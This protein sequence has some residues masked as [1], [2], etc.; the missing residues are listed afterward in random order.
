MT[1]MVIVEGCAPYSTSPYFLLFPRLRTPRRD[2]IRRMLGPWVTRVATSHL[3]TY[4]GVWPGP[5]AHRRSSVTATGRCAGDNN[6]SVTGTPGTLCS[7]VTA[8]RGVSSPTKCTLDA[9]P[10]NR[11]PTR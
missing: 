1:Y 6:S 11:T 4:L 8:S 5:E 2:G 3:S 7:G 9:Q 10:N